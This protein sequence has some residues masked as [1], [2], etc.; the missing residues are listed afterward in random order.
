MK[1]LL[2]MGIVDARFCNLSFV[3]NEEKKEAEKADVWHKSAQIEPV[4]QPKPFGY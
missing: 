2:K 3:E 4:T 1:R